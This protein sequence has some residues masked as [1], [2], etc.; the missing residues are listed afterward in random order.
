M[1]LRSLRP[2]PRR[3]GAAFGLALG[4][5]SLGL[6][7]CRAPAGP[8][9]RGPLPVQTQ[10]VQRA[11]FSSNV[12]TVSS[13]EAVDLVQLSTQAGG[14]IQQLLVRQGSQVRQGDLLL[15][16]DQVQ[17]GADVANLRAKAASDKL[18][19]ERYE[20]LVRQGAASPIQRDQFRQE[21]IASKEAL[22]AREADRRFRD[23]RAPISGTIADLQVKVG[24]VVEADK[25]FTKLVRNDRLMARLEVPATYA[26]RVRPGQ[27]VILIDPATEQPLRSGR[28][29]SID[30]LVGEGS[31]ALLAKAEFDNRDGRLR[32]GLR[33][34]TRLVLDQRDQ[35]SVPF[36]AVVQQAGQSFVYVP[37][38][39]AQLR[40]NPGRTDLASLGALPPGTQVA[41][42]VPVQLGPLQDNRYPVLSGLRGGERV[43]TSNLINLRHGLPI[44]PKP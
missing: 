26:D 27:T 21:Y 41:L 38:S 6:A 43:I 30:P 40:A 36:K 14:R 7:A 22:I 18:N 32:N 3:R 12:D 19:Y 25:P 5:A 1:D 15:V 11:S 8:P 13:L 2:Q 39:L 28:V 44:Q 10:P 31:Q 35:L 4:L 37:G 17:V 42:Q 23:L 9:A 16:L 24:D 34:R 20:L 29:Q 33:L